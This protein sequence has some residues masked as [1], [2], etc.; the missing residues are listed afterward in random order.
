MKTDLRRK[1]L[2][3]RGQGKTYTE[4]RKILSIPKS[5]LSN[6]LKG[7]ILSPDALKILTNKKK[8]SRDV[9]M[10]KTR[11]TKQ[12]KRE[13][14]FHIF[15][16]E[17]KLKLLPL[18]KREQY[19]AGLMLY[20]G[21]GV[22]GDNS[23][24]SLNNTDPKV[25]KFYYFWLTQ[26][27]FVKKEEVRVAVHLYQDMNMKKSLAFWSNYLSIPQNQ[28]IKPYIKKSNRSDIDQKGFGHGTCGIYIYNRLLKLRILAGI[29]AITGVV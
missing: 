13:M 21:E 18:N 24:V 27:L 19:L 22:K 17:E 8:L 5:T 6:W 4:I 12:K 14:R 3:L 16:K 11:L 29:N 9:A 1:A 20:L 23:T 10:E 25:V 2:E 28:F 26:V 15:S 7:N